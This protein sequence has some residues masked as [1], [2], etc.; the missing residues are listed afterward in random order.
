MGTRT[1]AVDAYIARSAAFARPILER[2]RDAFH[3]GAPEVVETIKWGAP[4]FDYKGP[5][6]SMAAF[7]EHVRW[8]FWKS[9][10]I[11]GAPGM[12]D[13]KLRTASELPPSKVMVA[14]VR[15][16]ARLNEEGIKLPRRP[17]KAAAPVRVPPDLERAL[18]GKKKAR[19]AFESM[20][21]SHRREYV[22]WI[23]EA[24]KEETRA[25]RIATALEW[26]AEG[27]S[28]NWKYERKR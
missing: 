9:K 15:E 27:K 12:S 24:K 3:A 19:E 13:G 1:A 5:L 4:H 23:T 22:E 20:P 14:F 26:L 10:L 16:A 11:E 2:V 6:G 25:R 28:R 17:R 8:G 21:P 18:A 7:R